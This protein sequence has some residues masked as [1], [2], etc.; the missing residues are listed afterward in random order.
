MVIRVGVYALPNIVNGI[1]TGT[2]WQED[3]VVVTEAPGDVT[4][5]DVV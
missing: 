3:I 1:E 5:V 4:T 2:E